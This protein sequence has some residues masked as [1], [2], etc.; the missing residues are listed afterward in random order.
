[1]GRASKIISSPVGTFHQD[2]YHHPKT[3]S[4]S[5]S[6]EYLS[7]SCRCSLIS[8]VP[9]QYEMSWWSISCTLH[10]RNK[11]V[12][13]NTSRNRIC[14][15]ICSPLF[16]FLICRA[17]GGSKRQ[18]PLLAPTLLFPPFMCCRTY[19]SSEPFK[20]SSFSYALLC[21][22]SSTATLG[23]SNSI[24]LFY[25]FFLFNFQ[26]NNIGLENE[27]EDIVRNVEAAGARLLDQVEGLRKLEGLLCV[28]VDL[29]FCFL[30]LAYRLLLVQDRL[31]VDLSLL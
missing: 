20:I 17:S 25:L 12:E 15:V 14:W 29:L 28:T 26:S 10:S 4:V 1:M 31:N 27:L 19:N 21:F 5:C 3:S 24:A 6:K 11:M 8:V 9:C 18:Q 23:R 13:G 30:K 7:S 2:S 22:C 16:S